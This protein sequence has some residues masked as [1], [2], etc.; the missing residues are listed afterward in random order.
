MIVRGEGCYVFDDKRQAL[1]RRALGAVLRQRRPRSRRNRRGGR[2]AG[3]RARLLHELEL[4]PPAIDRTGRED[5]R[6]GAGRSQPRLLHVGRLRVGRVGLEA[7]QELPQADRQPLEDEDR[8]AR[9]RLP[10]HD[11][12][13]A[14]RSPV[15][16]SLRTEFEPLVPGVR[17]APNTNDYHHDRRGT[18][19][20]W[21]LTR[22]RRS[23]SSRAQTPSPR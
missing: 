13:G 1:S 9:P 3:G 10:R 22:S 23:S 4:R 18:T 7:G 11:A 12:R 2:Q 16:P 6:T 14:R 20:C 5:R 15:S 19:R 17:H 8:R 21:R